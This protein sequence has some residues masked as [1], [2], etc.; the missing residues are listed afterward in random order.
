MRTLTVL[1]SL[2]LLLTFL[3]C[4]GGSE[5]T[6]KARTINVIGIDQLKFVVAEKS[7]GLQTGEEVTVN[8]KTYYALKGITAQAG[9]KI[10]VTLKAISKM[11][12][13]AMAHNW[14][15]LKKDSDPEAFTKASLQA[16]D[17]DYVAKEVE[18]LVITDTGLVSGGKSKSVT[19]KAPEQTGKYDYL[20]TFP[21]HFAA[22]MRGTLTVVP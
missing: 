19:F 7:D 10:T 4:S 14:L 12:A 5:S 16:K 13:K 2:V 20:C 1:S 11:P 15:L 3:S 9:E 8:G 6:P 21:G 22:G 17:N 18:D